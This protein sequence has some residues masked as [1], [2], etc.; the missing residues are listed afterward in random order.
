MHSRDFLLS[1]ML[2]RAGVR[3]AFFT[4]SGGGSP[5]ALAALGTSPDRLFLATQVHGCT[6]LE[7]GADDH[8]SAV[9]AT[10]ADALV[11]GTRG[12][13]LCVRTADCVP[14]LLASADGSVAGAVHA[15]WRG[16]EADIVG[17]AARR[18]AEL[19]ASP[20]GMLAAIGPH[21]GVAAF[22]VGDDVA[23]R[24]AACSTARDV[25][26]RAPGQKPHVDLEAIVRAQ[27]VAAGLEPS[28]V[29]RV[30]GCTHAEPELY[31]SFRR[32]AERSGR[33]LSAVVPGWD[34]SL[35][36]SST[37]SPDARARPAKS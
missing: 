23:E 17:V 26:V 11:S 34:A 9:S 19:G 21:I 31:H 30:G 2:R 1:P 5:G 14:I 29:E 27:L 15:G 37:P 8:P 36:E 13:A 3:H 32:D 18:L 16:V 20:A 4:R 12:I 10:E 24:L 35:A 28:R 22:E 6:V 33:S 25:V 7:V